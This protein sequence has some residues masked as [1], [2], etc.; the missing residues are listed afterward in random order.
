MDAPRLDVRSVLLFP[1]LGPAL[2]R[3]S[4]HFVRPY[5]PEPPDRTQGL[6]APRSLFTR[7]ATG[8]TP[9]FFLQHLDKTF[10]TYI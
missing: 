10:V 5:G 7:I 9:N 3:P 6:L 4:L 8:T 1:V 2:P